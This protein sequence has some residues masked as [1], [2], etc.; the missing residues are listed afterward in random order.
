MDPKQLIRDAVKVKAYLKEL[1]DGRLVAAKPLKIYLPTRFAERNLA[2]IGLET[3]IVGIAA[4]VVEDRYYGVLLV[5]ATMRIEPTSTLKVLVGDDEYFEFYFEAGSTVVS[6]VQL[7]KVDTLV[8]RIYDEI[9]AK[10]HCPWYLGYT[11]LGKLFDTA[12]TYAGANIGQNHEVTELIVSM[13]AR[14]AGDRHK[15]YRQTVK[16]AEDLKKN[17][18]VIIPLRS[19]QYSAT[20]TVNKLAGSFW[21]DSLVSTLVSPATRTEKLERLLRS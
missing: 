19:V 6:S 7:V 10:G 3:H 9:I 21:N 2:S 16:N 12:K 14:D 13:I 1:P 5:N 17:P 4:V 8:F 11:E 15:Y 18:P 20:N